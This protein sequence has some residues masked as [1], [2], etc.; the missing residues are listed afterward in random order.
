MVK[1]N[2]LSIHLAYL[3]CLLGASPFALAL[4]QEDEAFIKRY[5]APQW[6]IDALEGDSDFFK[7]I[8]KW[9]V[10]MQRQTPPLK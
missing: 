6:M 1:K 10:E 7:T 3:L 5:S 9:V 2:Q 8:N 4:S